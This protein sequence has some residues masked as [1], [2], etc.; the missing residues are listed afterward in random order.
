M[1]GTINLQ[2][3]LKQKFKNERT[4]KILELENEGIDLK[5]KDALFDAD[6]IGRKRLEEEMGKLQKEIEPLKR[7]SH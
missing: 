2:D 4:I 6:Y 1:N 5:I 3:L 7:K